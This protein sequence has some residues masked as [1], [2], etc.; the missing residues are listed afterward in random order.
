MN[1]NKYL[2]PVTKDQ[3]N[4]L[5]LF[6]NDVAGTNGVIDYAIQHGYNKNSVVDQ[7]KQF[8][9]FASDVVTRT[10]SKQLPI[11]A[12]LNSLNIAREALQRNVN[13]RD[14]ASH[15][16]LKEI[17]RLIGFFKSL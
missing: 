3:A 17:E 4:K 16:A 11:K 9:K 15:Q 5:V 10:N 13:D 8:K 14:V 2:V 7:A 1:V 6:A 12:V